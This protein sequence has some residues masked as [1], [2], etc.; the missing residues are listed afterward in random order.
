MVNNFDAPNFGAFSGGQGRAVTLRV[1]F[2][3]R[4]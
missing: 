1:R 3:G 4:K 2:I